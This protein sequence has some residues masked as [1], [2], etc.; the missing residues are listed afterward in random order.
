MPCFSGRNAQIQIAEQS[1]LTDATNVGAVESVSVEITTGLEPYHE[2]GS[3]TP[4]CLSEGNQ[5]ITGTVSR[6]WID[7]SLI[8]YLRKSV[9]DVLGNFHLIFRAGTATGAP[10][11]YLKSCKLE[12]AGIDISQDGFTMQDIAFRATE[13]D[14]GT[15]T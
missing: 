12:T 2:V 8:K 3:F 4:Y 5:E 6:M 10:Y 1:D 14:Y 9:S 15:V 11:V 13:W 7:T